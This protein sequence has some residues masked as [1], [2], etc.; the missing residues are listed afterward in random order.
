VPTVTFRIL[1]VFVVLEHER[2]KVVHI[3]VTES[4]T[5]R[6]TVQQMV[7]AFPYDSAPQYIL[8]DHDRTYGADFARRVRSVGIGEVLIAPRSPCQNP[9]CER[10]NGT[11]RRECT[12]HVIV[13]SER[14]FRGLFQD[15]LD[16]DH[17]ETLHQ[18]LDGALILGAT[19]SPGRGA[20]VRR[21]LLGGLPN[22]YH[23]EAA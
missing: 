16:Y 22:H 1:D 23:R 11:L 20:V 14:G 2:R 10:V 15:Y 5:A 17:E 12:R 4:P 13:L 19:R 21:Q 7:E 6:P 9:Y 3:L 18:G 8:R